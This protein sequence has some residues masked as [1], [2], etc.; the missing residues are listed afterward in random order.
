MLP[1]P[2]RDPLADVSS[3][4]LIRLSS[5]TPQHVSLSILACKQLKAEIS[6]YSPFTRIELQLYNGNLYISHWE[7]TP[8]MLPF[9]NSFHFSCYKNLSGT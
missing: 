8:L 9:C 1:L 4:Y 6:Y 3:D 5:Y 2:C 7:G